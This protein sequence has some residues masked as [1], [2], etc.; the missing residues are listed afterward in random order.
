MPRR[1]NRFS[2]LDSLYRTLKGNIPADNQEL[3]NYIEWRKGNRKITVSQKLSPEQRRR[4]GFAVLP[5][6]IELDAP[7]T[8]ADRYAAQ[9][10]AYSNTARNAAPISLSDTDLGYADIDGNTI[11]ND[12]FYPALIRV[13]V[14]DNPTADPT[15]KTSDI[16]GESYKRHAGR[17]YSIPFGRSATGDADGDV[18]SS[19]EENI[20]NALLAKVKPNP[21]VGSAT[22]EP[23]IFRT[24]RILASPTTT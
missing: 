7:P 15:D 22:Y 11:Q 19:G 4:Y 24:G 23:E 6:N 14:K 18:K 21:A 13:F 2:R 16:T 9:I 20:K 3:T 10:T 1:R 17:S 12:N 8:P 5:F